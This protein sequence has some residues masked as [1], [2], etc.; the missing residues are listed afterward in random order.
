MSFSPKDLNN[1]KEEYDWESMEAY[2]LNAYWYKYLS[3]ERKAE[4]RS[5]MR[6]M[7]PM[8]NMEI[9]PEPH[10]MANLSMA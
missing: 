1:T 2:D 8:T 3:E 10:S 9:D 6:R 5:Y 7:E 4:Y